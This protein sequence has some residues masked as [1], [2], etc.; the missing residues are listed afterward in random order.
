[1]ALL[2]PALFLAVINE[3]KLIIG[4][5]VSPYPLSEIDPCFGKEKVNKNIVI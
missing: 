3:G 1:M 4:R 2:L 5:S